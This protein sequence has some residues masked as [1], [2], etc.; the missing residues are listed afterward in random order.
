MIKS[1]SGSGQEVELLGPS[2]AAAY[3]GSSS[4]L[5]NKFRKDF[6]I[7]PEGI[8][9]VGTGFLYSLEALDACKEHLREEHDRV[10]ENVEVITD[11]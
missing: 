3:L 5:L 2:E 4:Y 8:Y 10:W 7:P 9:R 6:W 1:Q 11:G